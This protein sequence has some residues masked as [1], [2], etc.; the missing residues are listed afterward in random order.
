MRFYHVK[1]DYINFLRKYDEKVADN[2][3]ETRPYVGIVLE[4]DSMKYYA[5][6][7]SPQ[8]PDKL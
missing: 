2:N 3:H 8:Y 1:D 4:I 5:P 6:F 7:S